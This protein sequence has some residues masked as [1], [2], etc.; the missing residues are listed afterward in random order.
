MA[1][2]FAL[3]PQGVTLTP[4]T[5]ASTSTM[6]T[7][8]GNQILVKNEGTT[9]AFVATGPSTVVA[10]A[11]DMAILAGTVE[12]FTINPGHTTVSSIRASGSGNVYVYRSSGA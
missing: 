1:E 9:T 4:T 2:V 5:S 3:G 8:S 7:T 10:T 12:C 6:A 11:N